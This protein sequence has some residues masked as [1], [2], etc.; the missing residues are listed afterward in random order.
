V[1]PGFDVER[2]TAA[3]RSAAWDGELTVIRHVAAVRQSRA[4]PAA[5]ALF[6][7]VRK[8]GGQPRP[9][10]KTGTSDMN[11]VSERWPVPM[12]AYGPGDSSLDHGAAERIGVGE[13][14]RGVAVLASALDELEQD[15]GQLGGVMLPSLPRQRPG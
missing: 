10:L 7:A 5:R 4:N 11:T 3:L 2:F 8:H 13:Y 6:A 15:S 1:P 14:L 9:L 12:A